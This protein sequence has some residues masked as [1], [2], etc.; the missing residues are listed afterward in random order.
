MR[1]HPLLTAGLGAALLAADLSAQ[2][3]VPF[4]RWTDTGTVR[5][6][7]M[8][9]QDVRSLTTYDFAIDSATLVPAQ[10]NR[11]DVC[12][13]VGQIAPEVRFHVS[14]PTK[15]NGRLYMFGNG[16][17]A[18][19]PMD[20]PGRAA[21]RDRALAAGFA[22]TST[23]TGHDSAREPLASFATNPQK[24]IDYA[25]RAVHVTAMTA[26]EIARS[27]YG[28]AVNRSY[29]DG[30]STGGRQGL[31]SAQ[32]FPAD[33]DGIIVGAP[34]LDYTGTM[35]HLA[36][37]QQAMRNAPG[38]ANKF[39]LLAS[40]Y[41]GKC[42]EADGIADGIVDDP[43]R[44]PFDPATDVPACTAANAAA[45]DCL[46]DGE[47]AALKVL[48]GGVV[49]NGTTVFPGFTPG[50]EALMPSAS[51]PTAGW[52]GWMATRPGAPPPLLE[53]FVETFFKYMVTPG[54]EQ[55]FKTFDPAR[56]AAQLRAIATLLD[57]TDADLSAF[58]SRGGKILM[59]HGWAE[60][61]LT[62]LMSIK[63]VEQVQKTM[64]AQTDDFLRL[65][66]MPGVFHCGGGPGPDSFDRVTP[67]V[68][69]VERGTAPSRI[70]V[71]KLEGTAVKRTRP[72]CPY[73]Q[74]AAY[75]GTGSTDDAVNFE[76]RSP[77]S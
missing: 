63:Y 29:F 44:C 33:F 40:R 30:C 3:P 71:S 53:R 24:L 73:P 26:K 58:R 64:G 59:Y 61:A 31:T 37:I 38:L 42:D 45:N 19:E 21:M 13:V 8:R 39:E 72:L 5:T 66:M 47:I 75:T 49:V 10:E 56:D 46:T 28:T 67:L 36:L 2:M 77:G 6:T 62:P 9:C 76:C 51:G 25:Y 17:Y 41:Y 20:A 35:T 34:I 60:P 54:R 65:F 18:G 69:W 12:H 50:A 32:R 52:Q 68:D 48:Y 57:A 4:G 14:L 23:N 27:Y 55:D 7:K 22:V 43:R 11:P 1:H 70:V 15:W 16:G 74:V